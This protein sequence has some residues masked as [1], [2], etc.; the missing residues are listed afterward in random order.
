[1]KREKK[2]KNWKWSV[3]KSFR[4]RFISLFLCLVLYAAPIS[5]PRS[6]CN[7]GRNLRIPNWYLWTLYHTIYLNTTPCIHAYLHALQWWSWK[8]FNHYFSVLS[9]IS[10]RHTS[11]SISLSLRH[12]QHNNNSDNNNNHVKFFFMVNF[13]LCCVR[14]INAIW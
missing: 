2:K 13:P 4:R 6:G 3:N 5:L 12:T 1:M 11:I 10:L 14:L 8:M 9:V 7:N